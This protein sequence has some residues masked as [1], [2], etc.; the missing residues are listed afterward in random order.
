QRLDVQVESADAE[1]VVREL[2]TAGD[3][4]DVVI[5]NPPRRGI[6]P[7]TRAGI[8]RLAPS[9]VAYVSCEP[10]T[11]ARDISDLS[12]HGLARREAVP[13]D[14]MPLTEEVEA[15]AMLAPG[16][17]PLPEILYEDDALIAVVKAPHEP[18]TPQGEHAGSL[19]HRVRRIPGA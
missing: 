16:E 18:T 14:M 19:L 1:D 15:L 6:T 3:R 13:F 5:V 11:L 12:R 9:L 7:G 17:P 2:A 4:P 10:R 8:A